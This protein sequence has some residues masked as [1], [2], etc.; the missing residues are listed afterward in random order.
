MNK[1]FL[2]GYFNL[3]RG[4]SQDDPLSVYLFILCL[5]VFVRNIIRQ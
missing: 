4:T 5:E 3:N 2:T 1:G